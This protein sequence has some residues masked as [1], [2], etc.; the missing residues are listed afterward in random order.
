VNSDAAETFDVV[1]RSVGDIDGWLTREQASEL[2]RVAH[3]AAAPAA[4]VEIGSHHG[5]STILLARAKNDDVRLV[6][7]DPFEDARWGGGSEGLEV[8]RRNLS[9]GGVDGAVSFHR[10]TSATAAAEWPGGDVTLL[11]V[12]GA[13]D[14]ASVLLDLDAWQPHIQLGAHVYLHDAF[15]SPGVTAAIM[16]RFLFSNRYEYVGSVGSLAMFRRTDLGPL[17]ALA[18]SARLVARLAYFARNVGVKI[19]LRRDWSSLARL[20]RH[21][22]H[23]YPY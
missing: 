22:S 11:Y 12:D 6:A 2:F 9:R 8:F 18:S 13:H 17:A 1:W 20:L 7:V 19:A 23:E 10:G 16:Q 5:K 4:I 15:S 14:R 21:R 3:A